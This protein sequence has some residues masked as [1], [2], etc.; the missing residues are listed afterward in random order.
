M[1]ELPGSFAGRSSSPRPERGPEPSRRMSLAILV[2]D[3]A[4]VLQVPDRLTSWSLV[5]SASN[6]F[7]AVTNGSPVILAIS[8]ATSSA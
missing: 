7:G 4:S 5:A 6:L 8:A 1:I 3:T 2:S